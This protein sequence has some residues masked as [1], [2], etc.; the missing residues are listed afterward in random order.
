[1][2]LQSRQQLG[3]LLITTMLTATILTYEHFSPNAMIPIKGDVPTIGIGTTIYPNG[4]KV[5]LGDTITRVKAEEYL[6][7]DLDKFKQGMMKCIKA[8]LYQNEFDAYLSL[9][10]NIG[11]S[12]FCNSSIPFKLSQGDYYAA[13]KTILQFNKMRDVSKPKIR[14]PRTGQMQYQLKVIKGLDNRRKLEY[15]TCVLGM[16][17]PIAINTGGS[18]NA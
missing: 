13:C 11:T 7:H 10:Y 4:V 3:G 15:N 2:A 16:V 5:A 6:K 14:N 9:T 18:T 12:A 17:A 8:P 1:M